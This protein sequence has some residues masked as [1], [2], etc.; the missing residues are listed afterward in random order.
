MD[1]IQKRVQNGNAEGGQHVQRFLTGYM[2]RKWNIMVE[3]QVIPCKDWTESTSEDKHLHLRRECMTVPTSSLSPP[4]MFPMNLA[5]LPEG[6]QKE[7]RSLCKWGYDTWV[8][9][10]VFTDTCYCCG[11]SLILTG[12]SHVFYLKID[13]QKLVLYSR[14]VSHERLKYY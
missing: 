12:W 9:L 3:Q 6:E 5:P 13:E 11:Y 1:K 2:A 4:C 7:K 14:P 10:W 8:I